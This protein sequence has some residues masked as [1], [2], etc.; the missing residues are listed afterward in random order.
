[1]PNI[2]S[3]FEIGVGRVE[4]QP[5]YFPLIINIAHSTMMTF[6][7]CGEFV[8]GAEVMMQAAAVATQH[9]RPTD[10]LHFLYQMQ[11]LAERRGDLATARWARDEAERIGEG[12][13]GES[14]AIL[15]MMRASEAERLGDYAHATTFARQAYD[16]FAQLEECGDEHMAAGFSPGR[17]LEFDG[18]PHEALPYFREALLWAESTGNPIN[19][20]SILHHIG[21]CEAYAERYQAAMHAYRKAGEQFV[22]LGA[23]E[24]ISNAVGEAGLLVGR[25]DPLI[26][27]PNRKLVEAALADIFERLAQDLWRDPDV[28]GNPRVTLRKLAGVVALA[29]HIGHEGHLGDVAAV[30]YARLV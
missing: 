19:R 5:H 25:L 7:T 16:L 12:E 14:W 8:S 1:M 26:G 21:N 6:F 15:L 17:A 10:A 20:G 4:R 18:R 27:L 11:T 24:F 30:M 22:T 13:T 3:A 9:G 2:L 28:A 29:L 23:V